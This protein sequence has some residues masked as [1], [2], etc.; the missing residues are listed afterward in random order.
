MHLTLLPSR[1]SPLRWISRLL[2]LMISLF[3][4]LGLTATPALAQANPTLDVYFF[5]TQTCPYCKEQKPLMQAIDEKNPDIT[6]HVIDV[7]AEP[8]FW[9]DYRAQRGIASGAVP[10]T[11]IGE[12]SFV[13]YTKESGPL[14][15]TPAHSGYIGY[16][17]QIVGAIEQAV[18]HRIHTDTTNISAAPT[19]QRP[20]WL[21]AG[22]PLLYVATWPTAKR[23]LR[24]AQTRRYWLGGLAAVSLFSAFLFLSLTPDGVIRAFAQGLPFPLFVGIIALA[25]GFN[26][27]AFTVLIILLSLLTHTRHRKSMAWVGGTFVFTSAV[28]Y[29]LFIMGMI[30]VGS[31]LLAQLGPLFLMALGGGV[32][33]A[34]LINLKD[35]LWFKKGVSLSLSSEQQTAFTRRAGKIVRSLQTAKANRLKFAAALGG[36]VAL[37]VFVNLV[38]LGCTA[39]LPAVYMTTLI[40][41]CDARSLSPWFCFSG[42]TALYAAIYILPLVL[43]LANF[44]YSF[45]A[46]RLSETQG[47]R[48]KL[49]AGV[50]MLFFGLLM[51][52]HPELLLLA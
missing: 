37:A 25:D 50:F 34:G 19:P 35:Y 40:N 14:E 42:W 20:P 13:G 49:V 12:I 10:R 22:I 48:L 29:F 27:C 17:N 32:A 21:L 39:I 31:V 6:V 1:Y 47:R 3:L 9:A 7:N 51:V 5:I 2:G 18:G 28:M 52:L 26:P 11:S 33:I 30:G 44:I 8:Q 45:R 36:T 38:E 16:R 43:V 41:Y 46:T 4:M 23:R 24:E 15:Y